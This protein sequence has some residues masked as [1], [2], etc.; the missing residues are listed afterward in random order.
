ML[1]RT[2]T[3]LLPFVLSSPV[4]HML[5]V[6]ALPV[7]DAN[8]SAAL[9]ALV[10]LLLPGKELID[11]VIPDIHQVL[12]HTHAVV[13]P[14]SLIKAAKSVTR[15]IIALIAEPDSILPQ[16]ITA[17]LY[18]GAS[19]IPGQTPGAMKDFPPFLIYVTRVR[20][21][22]AAYSAVHPAGS[23][24]LLG[25]CLAHTTYPH[26]DYIDMPPTSTLIRPKP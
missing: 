7:M 14:V 9:R 11:T 24:Q 19:L 10:P 22:A 21:V 17:L 25:K 2:I 4:L 1:I 8:N 5:A 12:N 13:F 15:E 23:Y 16:V 20:K 18:V 6:I 3:P 26:P